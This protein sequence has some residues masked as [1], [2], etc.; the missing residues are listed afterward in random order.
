VNKLPKIVL[1]F[2]DGRA[3]KRPVYI[4]DVTTIISKIIEKDELRNKT[5]EVSCKE[6]ITVDN[7]ID[8]VTALTGKRKYKIHVPLN[9][10]IFIAQIM[11]SLFGSKSPISKDILLGLN[12]D[13]DFD[14]TDAVQI[15]KYAPQK[16]TEANLRKAVY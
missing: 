9:F 15:L 13:V 7:L 8:M 1:V 10:S 3:V 16:L 2:G 6:S 4:E 11:E 12:E 5:F 14:I